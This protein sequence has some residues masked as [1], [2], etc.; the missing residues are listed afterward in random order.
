MIVIYVW[1]LRRCACTCTSKTKVG[2][3][4]LLGIVMQRWAANVSADTSDPTV[5][6]LTRSV[7]L[8]TLS[9][10]HQGSHD[11]SGPLESSCI[12]EITVAGVP[13]PFV[14]GMRYW[15]T[16]RTFLGD[17]ENDKPKI[18]QNLANFPW[19]RGSLSNHSFASNF[20]LV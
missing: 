5:Q 6:S 11:T 19:N 15:K 3:N 10:Y 8:I 4:R 2:S 14:S 20:F 13:Y 1:M 7:R 18:L 16:L 17:G 12:C 9:M